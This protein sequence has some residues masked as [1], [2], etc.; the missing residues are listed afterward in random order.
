MGLICSFSIYAVIYSVGRGFLSNETNWII[1][2]VNI[3]L[4][5]I[6]AYYAYSTKQILNS[7]EKDRIRQRIQEITS[8]CLNPLRI[9]IEECKH[10]MN[11]KSHVTTKNGDEYQNIELELF[12]WSFDKGNV[13][14]LNYSFLHNSNKILV[15]PNFIES[16]F[17]YYYPKLNGLLTKYNEKVMNYQVFALNIFNDIIPKIDTIKMYF[18]ISDKNNWKQSKVPLVDPYGIPILSM[19]NL[20][21]VIFYGKMWDRTE[22]FD[23]D[24]SK[25]YNQIISDVNILRENSES[26]DG[27][28]HQLN[29]KDQELF[30]FLEEME[31]LLKEWLAEWENEYYISINN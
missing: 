13:F 19:D 1:I 20:F 18:N 25:I 12:D 15:N 8:V 28:I 29:E 30:N 2:G 21:T 23:N 22:L 26:V 11:R 16:T 14:D 6:T 17:K 31:K 7:G 5:G 24:G 9:Q 27:I 10:S 3:I 4:V